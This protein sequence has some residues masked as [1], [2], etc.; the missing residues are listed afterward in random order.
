MKSYS[1][2]LSFGNK[3][4]CR[5]YEKVENVSSYFANDFASYSMWKFERWFFTLLWWLYQLILDLFLF[6][7]CCCIQFTRVMSFLLLPSSFQISALLW[8]KKKI[9]MKCRT[10][11]DGNVDDDGRF[12]SLFLFPIS[13]IICV[14]FTLYLL[15]IYFVNSLP[16]LCLHFYLQMVQLLLSVFR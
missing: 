1:F 13:S 12:I 3:H 16:Q 6:F 8:K 2:F 15:N 9:E 5:T 4:S 11:R 10:T 7:R 14:R